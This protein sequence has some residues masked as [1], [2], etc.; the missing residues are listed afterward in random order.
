MRLSGQKILVT[1][2]AGYIGSHTCVQLLEHGAEVIILDNL[3]NSK[4]EVIARIEKITHHKPVLVKGDVRDRELLIKLFRRHSFDA[5]IHFAGLK[6]L[7]ESISKPLE[8][9]DNNVVGSIVLVEEMSR[10]GVKKIIFSSS[11][12]V[13]GDPITVPITEEFPLKT[14][15]PYGRSK[16]IVEDILRDLH[17]SDPTWNIAILRYFNP[18]GAHKSGMIGEDPNGVPS[19]LMPVIAQVAVGKIEKLSVY[20]GDYPTADGTGIRDYIHVDDLSRGHLA[21]LRLF[22]DKGCLM[23]LNL[24]TGCGCSV[25]EMISAFES[26]SGKK[27][28]H[29]IVDRR[30]GDVAE[31]YADSRRAKELLDWTPLHDIR[32][33]CN[34]L[35]R[36]QIMSSK[37]AEQDL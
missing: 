9:Y 30:P 16:L 12:T 23:T 37:R 13:Y 15:N 27:I 28:P 6:A 22:S 29:Q 2:G 19:N 4:E 25:L 18:V 17:K 32:E 10:A 20:G 34:D 8:Y 3:S 36:W 1:G 35:W 31:C 24:G 21:A 14:S 26:V 33:M 5:I 11:A 7:G